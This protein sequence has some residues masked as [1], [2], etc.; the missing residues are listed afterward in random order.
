MYGFV[1]D[2]ASGGLCVPLVTPSTLLLLSRGRVKFH[3]SPVFVGCPLPTH[4]LGYLAPE[5]RPNKQC[6][7][8]E[9]EKVIYNCITYIIYFVE[10]NI[11]CRRYLLCIFK[12]LIDL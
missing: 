11:K 8:T 9:T 3:Q 6:S 5:Y 1:I 12:N 4:Y 7:D 2:G 10:I